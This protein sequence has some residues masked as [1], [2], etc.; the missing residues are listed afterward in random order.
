MTNVLK[1][2]YPSVGRLE[3][4][5]CGAKQ[6]AACD[7]GVPY[8]PA[9]ARAAAAVAANPEKSNRS[10][11]EDIGVSLDTV[12]R[13][14]NESDERDRSTEKRTGKDGKRYPARKPRLVKSDEDMPTEEE[15]DASYQETLYD[16]A[17]LFLERMTGE[18]RQRLFAHI[19]KTY[20]GYT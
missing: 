3:C 9:G 1:M 13:A 6:D 20:H 15:A 8:V 7:C 14:R 12:N 19:R 18:T 10:I 16:Q 11:A 2:Q 4:S 17:C 5:A